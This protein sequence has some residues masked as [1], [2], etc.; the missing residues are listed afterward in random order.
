MMKEEK[1]EKN[2]RANQEGEYIT[3]QEVDAKQDKQIINNV[4]RGTSNKR[5]K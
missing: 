4:P 3:K 2:K 5:T 1:K